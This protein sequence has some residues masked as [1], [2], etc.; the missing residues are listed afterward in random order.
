MSVPIHL[1]LCSGRYILCGLS[2][3]TCSSLRLICESVVSNVV[4]TKG[5]CIYI[6]H[7]LVAWLLGCLVAW[8][9]GCLVV[10]LFGYLFGCCL[11]VRSPLVR[12]FVC[13]FVRSFVCLPSLPPAPPTGPSIPPSIL[14]VD[15]ST[16]RVR[17]CAYSQS[18]LPSSAPSLRS[19]AM[20][21]TYNPMRSFP[22]SHICAEP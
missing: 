16:P 11:L 13:L 19:R 15:N 17:E 18:V 5:S 8:L 2:A 7:C 1:S 22:T 20:Q 9:F 14:D 10:W 21:H 6:R 12:P 4:L 3:G